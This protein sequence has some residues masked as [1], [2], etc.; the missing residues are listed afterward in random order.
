MDLP[1]ATLGPIGKMPIAPGT[2]GSAVAVILWWILL[3]RRSLVVKWSAIAIATVVAIWTADRAERILGHDASPIVIDELVGQW[4]ALAF[5]SNKISHII[6]A[7]FLFRLFDIWKP[8]PAR[9]SQNLPGGWGVVIDDLIAGGYT[10]LIL[11]IIRK[12]WNG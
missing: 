3:S 9:D 11:A 12:V 4:V 10:G 1:I 5:C 8:F 6:A 7:F 2:W